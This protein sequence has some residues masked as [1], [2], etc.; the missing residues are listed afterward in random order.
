MKKLLFAILIFCSTAA[1]A[2]SFVADVSY[3]GATMLGATVNVQHVIGGQDGWQCLLEVYATPKPAAP[4]QWIPSLALTV[5]GLL[6]YVSDTDTP[7]VMC[8]NAAKVMSYFSN[9]H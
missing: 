7:M 9:I 3:M 2:A 1:G 6:P 4:A 5:P 8:L